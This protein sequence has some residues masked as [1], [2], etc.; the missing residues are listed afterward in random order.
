MSVAERITALREHLR[1]L[2][3]QHQREPGA[4]KLLPISKRHPSSAIVQAWDTGCRHFGENYVQEALAKQEAL[5]EY[6]IQWH[7]TGRLQRNKT[8]AVASHFS[9]VHGLDSVVLAE[10]LSAA[11][12]AE[13]PDLQVCIQLNYDAEAN[14]SGV[15]AAELEEVAVAV[16]A[17]PRLSL[18]GL[19][20]LPRPREEYA[21]QL[22]VFR[23]VAKQLQQLQQCGLTCDTLSMG[24]TQD[25]P[26]AVA[27]GATWVRVG[28]A[29]FGP[30]E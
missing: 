9:W 30:R 17:L 1:A 7:F 18:R 10:R 29:I 15:S 19:M 4:V 16:A 22:Q 21:E 14:K 25:Y 3:Q 20:V 12:P 24:M 11:R 28:T 13:L 26:A 23:A 6:D 8:T 5:A 2:E 27:A